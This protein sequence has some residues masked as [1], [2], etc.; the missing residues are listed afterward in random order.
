MIILKPEE[1]KGTPESQH[2][3][4]LV[5]KHGKKGRGLILGKAAPLLPKIQL[6]KNAARALRTTDLGGLVHSY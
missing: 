5:W 6:T 2:K 4:K 1:R 3:P